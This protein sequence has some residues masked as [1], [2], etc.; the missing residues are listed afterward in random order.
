MPPVGKA[1]SFYLLGPL[2]GLVAGWASVKMAE[3]G[4]EQGPTGRPPSSSPWQREAR[5]AVPLAE[6]EE[7]MAAARRIAEAEKRLGKGNIS[8]YVTDWT[9]ARSSPR[10]RRR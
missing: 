1:L 6:R 4:R 5:E 9:D 2:L 7:L 8:P 3:G 10:W